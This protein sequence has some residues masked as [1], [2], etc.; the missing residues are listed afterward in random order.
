[1]ICHCGIDHDTEL[2]VAPAVRMIDTGGRDYIV[3]VQGCR[4]VQLMR[5]RNEPTESLWH[6]ADSSMATRFTLAEAEAML[7]RWIENDSQYF[8][9][10]P[11]ESKVVLAL[12]A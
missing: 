12:T 8:R 6:V 4:F 2:S 7:S 1:M 10:E 9:H 5:W 3:I 11:S